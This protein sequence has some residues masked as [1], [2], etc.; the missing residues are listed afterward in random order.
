MYW[1]SVTE[2]F[3]SNSPPNRR[4]RPKH[5]KDHWGKS[6]KKVVLFNG[7]WCRLRDVYASGQSDDQLLE[8]AHA[9]YKAE[10]KQCFTLVYWWKFV[11]D[12]P[13]WMRSYD[14]G[15]KKKKVPISVQIEG[16]IRPP[17][18]KTA[19]AKAAMPNTSLSHDDLQIYYDT[20]ALRASTAEKSADVQLRL[21]GEKLE[22]TQ[23]QERTSMA[24]MY[25]D[26]LM[27]DLSVMTDLQRI[28]H[29][30]ALQYFG[31]KIHGANYND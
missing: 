29:Q 22:A 2:E 7:I 16:E 8:K 18:T 6:N 13:K 12:H 14:E 31:D 20:Q 21:S 4:R 30:R 28:E 15:K 5:C 24:K 9:M 23:A 26:L 25:T 3:N 10:A 11:R 1:K 27:A 17:G 19:K